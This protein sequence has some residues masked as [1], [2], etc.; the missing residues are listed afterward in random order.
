MAAGR[1]AN[2][3]VGLVA[4]VLAFQLSSQQSGAEGIPQTPAQQQDGSSANTHILSDSDRPANS[5]VSLQGSQ[6]VRSLLGTAPANTPIT[7]T[8]HAADSS[9]NTPTALVQPLSCSAAQH[10]QLDSISI[11]HSAAS[12]DAITTLP[13]R[14]TCSQR[15]P[16]RLF[17]PAAVQSSQSYIWL[18][19]QLV[20]PSVAVQLWQLFTA[21]TCGAASIPCITAA[22]PAAVVQSSLE[23][24]ETDGIA[25][26][27][28]SMPSSN[29]GLVGQ[30]LTLVLQ[31]DP[32]N[33][34]GTAANFTV[35]VITGVPQGTLRMA[36][37]PSLTNSSFKV[38]ADFN[39]NIASFNL[40]RLLAGNVSSIS[41][42]AWTA[43]DSFVIYGDGTAGSTV[44]LQMQAGSFQDTTYTTSTNDTN[45]VT[46][47]IPALQEIMPAFSTAA[48]RILPYALGLSGIACSVAVAAIPGGAESRSLELSISTAVV[49]LICFCTVFPP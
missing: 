43:D 37:S 39:H 42:I 4:F 48:Q 8:A 46:A 33:P 21:A 26:I 16:F 45:S 40:S 9:G 38:V 1:R 6:G 12:A 10:V 49:R 36:S 32:C 7:D 44:K 23:T 22:P 34:V 29:S 35:D 15:P 31:A 13:T 41:T 25:R 18:V 30:T 47:H 3:A 17:I 2:A 11:E 28:V 20:N 19:L 5:P 27:Q 24:S 14:A